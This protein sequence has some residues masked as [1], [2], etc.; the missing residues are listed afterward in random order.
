MVP[1]LP[2]KAHRSEAACMD[3][4]WS[5]NDQSSG[6]WAGTLVILSRVTVSILKSW[7]AC[8]TS[9]KLTEFCD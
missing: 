4:G 9:S 3:V 8:F 1:V 2:S 6:I 7:S 5:M